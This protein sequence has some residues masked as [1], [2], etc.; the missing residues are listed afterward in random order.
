MK[1]ENTT[2]TPIYLA[3][4]MSKVL[5]NEESFNLMHKVGPRVC[6]TTAHTRDL[7]VL[8]LISKQAFCLLQVD[9]GAAAFTWKHTEPCPQLS[10]YHVETLARS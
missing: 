3:L 10:V 4:N 9:T 8:W 2:E 5:N 6:I 7:S 1:T